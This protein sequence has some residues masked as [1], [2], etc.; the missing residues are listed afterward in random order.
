MK[1]SPSIYRLLAVLLMGGVAGCDVKVNNPP[2]ERVVEKDTTIVNPP[3][4]EKK[5]ESTTTVKKSA[6]GVDVEKTTT[7]KE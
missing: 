7:T 4:T 3:A 1:M 5:T 6:D 2:G